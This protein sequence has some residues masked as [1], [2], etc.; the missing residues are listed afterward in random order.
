MLPGDA[1]FNNTEQL[2]VL[3]VDGSFALPEQIHY[4][5]HVGIIEFQLHEVFYP[6]LGE[7]GFRK[8]SWVAVLYALIRPGTPSSDP[9]K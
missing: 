8:A 3:L 4:L 9:P 6:P 2:K 5:T 1:G 7:G